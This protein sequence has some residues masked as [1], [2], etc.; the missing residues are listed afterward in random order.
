MRAS[1]KRLD[2]LY[3]KSD[4]GAYLEKLLEERC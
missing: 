4:Y 2:K 1:L 3:S